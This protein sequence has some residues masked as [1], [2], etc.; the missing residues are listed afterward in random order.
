[1]LKMEAQ[2]HFRASYHYTDWAILSTGF[3]NHSTLFPQK[4]PLKTPAMFFS[5]MQNKMQF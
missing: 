1:M 4:H 2:V 5:N 3:H